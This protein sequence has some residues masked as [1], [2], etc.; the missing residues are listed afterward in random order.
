MFRSIAVCFVLLNVSAASANASTLS[1][2]WRETAD[3][4]ISL[5]PL[6]TAVLEV[7]MEVPNVDQVAGVSF[8]LE[9][10]FEDPITHVANATSVP[11]WLV[12]N[13]ST[14]NPL[15]IARFSAIA[16]DLDND[17]VGGGLIV[18]GTII[19][20]LEE[21][22]FPTGTIMNI[23]FDPAADTNVI[24]PDGS[25]ATF[26]LNR[27]GYASYSGYWTYGKGRPSLVSM[28]PW[29]PYDPLHIRYVLPEPTSIALVA[30][31]GLA[32]IMRQRR[33]RDARQ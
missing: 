31:S 13:D 32:L 10:M 12:D 26:T 22:S 19:L 18:L 1:L 33:S 21:V 14:P 6:Q 9:A 17:S 7:V 2:R 27:N 5:S 29:P 4:T 11:N 24:N 23:A 16:D 3:D 15:G 28:V 30:A 25:Q 20:R 8:S